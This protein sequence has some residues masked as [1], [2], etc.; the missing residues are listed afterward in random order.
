MHFHSPFFWLFLIFIPLYL[1]FVFKRKKEGKLEAVKISVFED[2]K[3]VKKKSWRD[4]LPF[5]EHFLIIVLIFLFTFTL[6]RIQKEYEKTS[7]SKEGIDIIVALDV[8]GSMLAEDLHPSRI[9]AAKENIKEFFT[10][11]KNDRLAVII[12]AGKAFTQ[13]PLTFDKNI[14]L[15]HIEKIS[16]QSINQG[17]RGL[18]GTAVGDAI[19]AAINR[20]KKSEDRSKV[21]ILLTD[22]EANVGIKPSL[23]AQMAKKDNIKIYTIGIGSE[24][25]VKIPYKNHF[26]QKV[27]SNQMATFDEKSLQ[28]IAQLTDGQYYRA[29]DNQKLQKIFEQISLLEKKELK[30]ETFTQFQEGFF[31]FL[32]TLFVIFFIF[33]IVRVL[34]I[35]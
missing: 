26:G 5:L 31:P 12:F 2:L 10:Q 3:K 14:L 24:G 1:F 29:N 13:S 20:F 4:F 19:L 18:S 9:E 8:S 11:I 23:A 6:A 33:M 16:T 35:L 25:K 27:Y 28:E 17:V 15:E 21:L 30:I 22:G 34:I 32:I 7:F